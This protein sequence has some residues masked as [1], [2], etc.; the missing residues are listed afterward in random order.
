MTTPTTPRPA[1]EAVEAALVFCKDEFSDNYNWK[2]CWNNFTAARILATEVEW[3]RYE[4]E[5]Q[6]DTI[7][8]QGVDLI[9]FTGEIQ[10]LRAQ[11]KSRC[12]E[13][14]AALE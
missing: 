5:Q 1:P 11:I 2:L 7:Q 10:N 8:R 4:A 13:C 12:G 14:G 9:L 6:R 3:L